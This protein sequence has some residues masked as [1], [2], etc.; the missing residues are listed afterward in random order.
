MASRDIPGLF[1][2]SSI[3]FTFVFFLWH[4]PVN[5]HT[6]LLMVSNR[7]GPWTHE[8]PK[9]SQVLCGPFGRLLGNLGLGRLE[10]GL[11][12]GNLTHTTKQH[13]LFQP[14][15]ELRYHL[16]VSNRRRPRTPETP[17]A[18]QVRC[19]LLGVRNLRVVLPN[20]MGNLVFGILTY[21]TKHN[22]SVA[23]RRFS[24]VVSLRSSRP[25]PA[26]A[27]LSYT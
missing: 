22:T 27:W 7:R 25:I 21:T 4:K 26:E 13:T 9:A 19:G 20:L 2:N 11:A 24:V 18:L 6:N 5:E 14:V 17:E 1:M 15:N 12:F 23:S 16:M 10:K 3:I 8:T